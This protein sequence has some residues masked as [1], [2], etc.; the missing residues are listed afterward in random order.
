[1]LARYLEQQA[2]ITAALTSPELRQ[3]ARSID[4]LDSCDVRD[5]EDLVKLLHPLKKATTVLCEEKSPTVSLIVPLKSMIEQSMTPNDGDSTT[6]A[7]TKTAIL[8]NIAN[9]YSGDAFNYLVECTVLDPR[10]RSLPQL[11]QDQCKAVFL[12][13]QNKAEQLLQKQTTAEEREEGAAGGAHCPTPSR[14]ET[15]RDDE[16]ELAKS[17]VSQSAPKKTK[18]LGQD[19]SSAP[20]IS[21]GDCTLEVVEDFTYLG[22]TISSS[23]NLDTELN[24][25]IGEAS[26]AMARLSKR[27]WDNSMLTIKT[28][29]TVYQ[30]CVLG[31]LLY[32]S[33][34][35]T[36]YSRQKSAGSF[37]FTSKRVAS[38]YQALKQWQQ[39]AAPGN[40]LSSQLL[41]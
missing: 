27:V 20:C 5:A 3:N 14:E 9:R 24:S 7:N 28:K 34:C 41:R 11:D 38:H 21:I 33:E 36:L 35:W 25:R 10:F 40:L 19:V 39:T 4:T 16:P 17:S 8:T 13:V 12:R 22:S 6:M 26:S 23:L 30:A 29:I 1:M 15:V 2:A 32:G 37:G 31:T 18:V